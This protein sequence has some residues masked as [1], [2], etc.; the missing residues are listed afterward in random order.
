MSGVDLPSVGLDPATR[1]HVL[2]VAILPADRLR[3]VERGH[4]GVG[5]RAHLVGVNGTAGGIHGPH[6]SDDRSDRRRC[7]G[8]LDSGGR[9]N[10]KRCGHANRS[11][12]AG[13]VGARGGAGSGAGAVARMRALCS[14]AG[15]PEANSVPACPVFG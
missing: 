1:A 15:E 8:G 9:G 6:G 7:L 12:W 14:V 3:G 4:Q 5:P 10:G 2:L 13:S 11:S